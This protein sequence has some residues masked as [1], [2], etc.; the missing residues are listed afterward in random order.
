MAQD[1][2]SLSSYM[3]CGCLDIYSAAAAVAGWSVL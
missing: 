2:V 1:V 3:S